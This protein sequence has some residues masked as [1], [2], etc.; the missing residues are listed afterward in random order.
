MN[1]VLSFKPIETKYVAKISKEIF[2]IVELFEIKEIFDEMSD[3]FSKP[4]RSQNRISF[5]LEQIGIRRADVMHNENSIVFSIPADLD[6]KDGV[7]RFKA[8]TIIEE[9]CKYCV[10][11]QQAEKNAE[12][13]TLVI[14]ERPF[15]P[16]GT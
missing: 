11:R 5:K 9:H 15:L 2:E 10:E 14:D 13:A 4:D 7:L 6:D 16:H 8:M 3:E 12:V 1:A